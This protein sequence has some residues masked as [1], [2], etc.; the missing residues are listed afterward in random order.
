MTWING[1]FT[2]SHA[3]TSEEFLSYVST[4]THDIDIGLHVAIMSVRD[5]PV[6]DENGLMVHT[7]N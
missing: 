6:L 7:N 4:L 5:V 3:A 2:S 1:G